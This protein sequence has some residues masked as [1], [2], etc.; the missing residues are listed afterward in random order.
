MIPF[1]NETV[2]LIKRIETVTEGKTHVSYKR[3]V[4]QGCSWKKSV[5]RTV[6]DSEANRN[7]EITCRIPAGQNAP[8]VGDCL[9]LGNLRLDIATSNDLA[10][11][12]KANEARGA[13]RAN[14]VS[15]NSRPGVPLPHFVAKG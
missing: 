13:F 4:L 6:F 1:G 10:A 8:A 7:A 3:Y 14:F 11:A 9:F 5:S 2:T 15:D 12:L